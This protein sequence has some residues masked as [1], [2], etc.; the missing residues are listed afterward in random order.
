[1][2]IFVFK[3]KTFSRS[4]G[5]RGSRATSAAAYRAG[6]R[7]RD[8][9]TDALYDHRRRQ[10]VLHKEI[11]VPAALSSRGSAPEWA[12]TRTALWN[13]AERAET[14]RNSRVAR[15]FMVAL[16]HELA[17]AARLQLAQRYAHELSDRYGIAIDLVIH[18][19]RTDPRNF[20]AHLLGTTR[21]VTERGLGRKAALELSGTERHRRGLAR[22]VQEKTWLRERWAEHTNQ[23]LRQAHLQVR[24]SHLA[25]AAPDLTRSPRLPIAA[26]YME[27]QGRHS[28]LAERIRA[29]H[30][31]RLA[32]SGVPAPAP[33]LAPS[34]P[35]PWRWL[36]QVRER[37]RTAWLG[38]R[39]Q[40]RDRP[41]IAALRQRTHSNANANTNTN[42]NAHA[43]TAGQQHERAR[44]VATTQPA[45]ALQSRSAGADQSHSPRRYAPA[46]TR[47]YVP[48]IDDAVRESLRNWHA[49]RQSHPELSADPARSLRNWHAY[50]QSHPELSTDPA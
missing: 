48:Q 13:A 3:M 40:L 39:E 21:E 10:D 44:K 35:S 20:H 6:E 2:A 16:P 23:A 9:R 7:I 29:R 4:A 5:S 1:M 17:P 26:Y 43:R 41:V 31:A 22:W 42:T 49:Y 30:Q 24:V 33:P 19:P 37:A 34:A 28:F 25:P 32:L 45:I 36:G 46:Y 15:E 27:K 14:R 8:Q 47:P 38:V 11:I 18:S 50:R 12:R